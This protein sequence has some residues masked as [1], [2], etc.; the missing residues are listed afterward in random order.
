MDQE[1]VPIQIDSFLIELEKIES[2]SE[3]GESADLSWDRLERW[4]SRVNRH[5]EDHLPSEEID[6]FPDES[7]IFADLNEEIE[8]CRSYLVALRDD[9]LSH[10]TEHQV[11][12]TGISGSS[13]NVNESES[14]LKNTIEKVG[15]HP[16][17]LLVTVVATVVIG[18]GQFT[19]SIKSLAGVFPAKVEGKAAAQQK[20]ES[21]PGSIQ[22]GGDVNIS[23]ESGS[24][25]PS[26]VAKFPFNV[27]IAQS[28]ERIRYLS[29]DYLKTDRLSLV[30]VN[31]AYGDNRLD[32][33]ELYDWDKVIHELEKQRFIKVIRRTSRGNIEFQ[34]L[35]KK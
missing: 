5:L 29:E 2:K 26:P 10:S 27:Q 13:S 30:E 25:H 7:H 18:L 22:A 4:K 19:D 14:F 32:A 33:P 23:I 31:G 24:V 1:P 15:N 35:K 11:A 16:F 8:R 6:D 21:S 9:L 34:V 3:E 28:K 17:V 12:S 20:M